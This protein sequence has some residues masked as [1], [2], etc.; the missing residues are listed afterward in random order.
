MIGKEDLEQRL[1][2][3][4]WTLYKLAKQ[5]SILRAA[6]GDVSPATR[7]QTA[8]GKAMENP[9]K[10]K[11]ET[12]EGIIQALNGEL[13]IFW[14]PE[15]VVTIQLDDQLMEVLKQRASADG[16]AIHEV[17]KQLFEQ[18]LSGIPAHKPRKLTDLIIAEEPKIYRSFHPRIAS[19]YS[20]VHQ[21][22]NQRPEAEG[23]KE[24]D[25]CKDL[26]LS[27]DKSDLK[28]T[29]FQY[30][31]LFPRYYF[32]SAHVLENVIHSTRFLKGL[33]YNPRICVVDIGCVMGAASAALIERILT[34]QKD[35]NISNPIEIVCL[36]I[37]PSI[38][39]I[40]LYSKLMQELKQNLSSLNINLEFQPI[41]E[42]VPQ[43]MITAMRYLQKKREV[44][45]QPVLSNL[46]L[47]QIDAA[48]S[49]SEDQLL[50]REQ[51]EKLKELGVETDLILETDKEFWQAEA[52]GYKQLLE[53]VPIE[54]LCLMLLGTKNLTKYIQEN[55]QFNQVIDV[56]PSINQALKK[57][58]GDSHHGSILFEGEQQVHFE[59]PLDSYWQTQSYSSKFQA[60]I[61][62]ISSRKLETDQDWNKLISLENLEL[63]WVRAR[64]N[65]LNE[66][67]YDEI[68]I[69]LFENNLD[70]NLSFM[71]Q[72]LMAYCD[73]VIPVNQ[74]IPYNFVKGTSAT[75][76]KQLSRLEEEILSTAIIETIGNKVGLEFSSYR[77][78]KADDENT[79]E[80]LYENWWEGYTNFRKKA[81][82]AAKKYPKGAVIRT[83]IK[84]FYTKVIQNQLLEI[85]K[86]QLKINSERLLWL[87]K[88]TLSKDLSG[89]QPGNGL[90]QGT[91]TSGFYANLYLS[92]IDSIFNNDRRWLLKFYRYV[93]DIIII[94]PRSSYIDAVQQKL[95]DEL[96]KLGLELNQDKTEHYDNIGAFLETMEDDACLE[97]LSKKFNKIL[98]NLWIMNSTYRLGLE[99]AHH[100]ETESSWWERIHLYQQCL[101][102][103][104]IYVTET[105]L[106]RKIYQYLFQQ[107]TYRNRELD[108]P[109]FPSSDNFSLISNWARAFEV[110]QPTWLNDRNSLKAEIIKLFKQSL[111]EL[112]GIVEKLKN[113]DPHERPKLLIK[114]RK[115]ET[116]IRFSV[117]KL[118]I[119]GFEE[120]WEEV[121][122]L[123]CGEIFVIRDLLEVVTKLARQGY[124]EAIKRLWE[125]YQNN[126][127]PTSEYI[128]A[129]I[130]E[131]IRFLPSIDLENWELI[132]ES[133]TRGQSDIERLKATETWLYL[134]DVAKSFVQNYHIQAVIK[135]LNSGTPPFTRLKK[136]YI[137]ILG[138]HDPDAI[139]NIEIS[140]KDKEEYIIRDALKLALEGKVS[141]LFTED[142][143]AI[144]RQYYSVKRAT[145]GD[146]KPYYSL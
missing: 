85:T 92:H 22:L 81:Q 82:E 100:S 138:M 16:A 2:D 107:N 131:A 101:Y 34:L 46:F 13:T 117:N 47:M 118:T 31:T 65:L 102:S 86:E 77:P 26:W 3:L 66:A 89:H 32:E 134:G 126:K 96:T 39:G 124:V 4:G 128:R 94:L 28:S 40:T 72:Q 133:A 51:Y 135:A 8:I 67:C 1:K 141:E 6:D 44:W 105:Y 42:R 27:L 145:T 93:D 59:N 103:I 63:A 45:G 98:L 17:A 9:A 11:L 74:A 108:L 79:T 109:P 49:I 113:I 143:P 112:R 48:S 64:H 78:Q 54:H 121:V 21:W 91:I 36:G 130:L 122:D 76:P 53:E 140:Q 33:K 90:S 23:Y 7:Y 68:E 70:S 69:R 38:Y 37:D 104:Q 139:F 14:E 24:L 114:Q 55:S 106:S 123:I 18:A 73:E 60:S 136:N 12:I 52:L 137:L 125:C 29:A 120:V 57:I 43:A 15:Q 58:I 56:L 10:S 127:R 88:I 111:T 41:C 87:L 84:S 146:D 20:A 25:Y 95:E 62:T 75:R 97:E 144:V 83:D 142:E 110:L 30:Y 71:Q 99:F 129:V 115:L 19:A 119:L 80:Y 5:F 35:E 116:R 132:F 50:K 61:H